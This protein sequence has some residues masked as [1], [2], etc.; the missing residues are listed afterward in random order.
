M[1]IEISGP[2]DPP[3]I[4]VRMLIERSSAKPFAEYYSQ[5]FPDHVIVTEDGTCRLPRYEFHE[6]TG[7]KPHLLIASSDE[8]IFLDDPEGGYDVMEN[9]IQVYSDLKASKLILIDNIQAE[10]ENL[11]YVA[12]TSK[13]LT[14]RLKTLDV[15]FLGDTW[16]AG[17]AGILLGLCNLKSID[18]LGIFIN[19]TFEET[20]ERK[21]ET[22][23][24][25]IR[26]LFKMKYP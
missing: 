21:A 5:H 15:K 8:G 26:D 4:A 3:G 12:S 23:L 25:L 19:Q 16:L 11:L 1:V 17:P 14:A 2:N 10:P 20:P 7:T 22:S 24:N 18:G 13:R 9:L 6:S